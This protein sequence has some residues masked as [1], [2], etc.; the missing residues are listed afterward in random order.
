MFLV[1]R[2]LPLHIIAAQLT[3]VASADGGPPSYQMRR[4]LPSRHPSPPEELSCG[5]FQSVSAKPL[6]AQL[7]LYSF[8]LQIQTLAP[9]SVSGSS[10]RLWTVA[11]LQES[12]PWVISS[13]ATFLT[14]LSLSLSP[15]SSPPVPP[16]PQNPKPYL[17]N[18]LGASSPCP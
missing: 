3:P 9:C 16:S 17:N 13:A 1:I 2:N 18:L 14:L 5:C 15:G 6:S 12:C 11:G 7:L 10:C 4:I 8:L